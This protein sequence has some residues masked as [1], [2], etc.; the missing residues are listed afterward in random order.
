MNTMGVE[1]NT[2][3]PS[4]YL[5]YIACP[6][7][8]YFRH[9]G[10]SETHKKSYYR[11]LGSLIHHAVFYF[12]ADFSEGWQRSKSKTFDEVELF[13][14]NYLL[15]N[16][17]D[18]STLNNLFVKGEIRVSEKRRV[19]SDK[20]Y[21][22]VLSEV[23]DTIKFLQKLLNF[24][25]LIAIEE[26][27]Q[28]SIADY[29][30]VG[31]VDFVLKNENYKFIEIKTSDRFL[32]R[33]IS[34]QMFVYSYLIKK[35]FDL[36]YYPKGAMYFTKSRVY[37]IYDFSSSYKKYFDII[38]YVEKSI[39]NNIFYRTYNDSCKTCTF[40]GHCNFVK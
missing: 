8:F 7:S 35:K 24:N 12:Y 17:E 20:F 28:G 29:K 27:I 39:K 30:V 32:N 21:Y 9:T 3:S 23:F 16:F 31:I 2:L 40:R 14:R 6:M 15:S 5:H 18:N 22:T 10:I 36:N 4:S 37:K 19:I 11:W 25:E 13:V 1:V 26:K 38:N 34:L 33:D